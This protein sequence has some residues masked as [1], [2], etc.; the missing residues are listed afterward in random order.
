ML[1]SDLQREVLDLCRTYR[2]RVFHSTDSTKDLG[3]GYP[4]LCIVGKRLI[5]AELKS[6]H[7]AMSGTQTNWRYW[8]KAAGTE[9]YIWRPT[10]LA[11]GTITTILS[12][13]ATIREES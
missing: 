2:L 9:H 7:G 4:D 13:L 1:E 6:Q 3:P 11:D 8:I 5:F 10:D 12:S